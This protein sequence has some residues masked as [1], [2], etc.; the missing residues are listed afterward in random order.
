M[1][2]DKF[3]MTNFQFRLS[4]LVAACR[5]ASS[6]LCAFALKSCAFAALALLWSGLPQA[7][8]GSFLTNSPMSTARSVHTATLLR[9]GKVLVA[10]GAGEDHN[11]AFGELY[12]PATGSWSLTGP[13]HHARIK[14]TATLLADGR[15]LVTGGVRYI[16]ARPELYDPATGNWTETGPLTAVRYPRAATLL[17]GGKVLLMGDSAQGTSTTEIYD[18]DYDKESPL[19]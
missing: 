16:E 13:M 15:V 14:Q 10:G 18:P 2:N 1:T 3:S 6:R 4:V 12:D 7:Q 19:R 9:N 8:A 5:A 17:P 11:H